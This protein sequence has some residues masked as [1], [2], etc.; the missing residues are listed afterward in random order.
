MHI[1]N[2]KNKQI[3]EL[4]L[5]DNEYLIKVPVKESFL[6][7]YHKF[8]FTLEERE[9]GHILPISATETEKQNEFR[10]FK[11]FLPF[12]DYENTFLENDIWNVYLV[13]ED[14]DGYQKRSRIA[15]NYDDIRF[16]TI[17]VPE[18]ELMFYP[19]RTKKGKL[20]FRMNDYFTYGMFDE[21]ALTE[22]DL[23]FSGYFNFPPYYKT[24]DYEIKDISLIVTDNTSE[25]EY[26]I[27]LERFE[28]HD[29]QDK[30]EGN[31]NLV[32][33]GIKG[34]FDIPATLS[35]DQKHYFKFHLEI[36][37]LKDSEMFSMRSSRVRVDH[38]SIQLPEKKVIN[39][40]N[41]KAKLLVKSTKYS[42]Y[43]SFQMSYYNFKRELKKS[44]KNKWV[45]TRRS[46]KLLQAYKLAFFLL[47]KLPVKK[48][49]IMFESFLGKQFSDSPR[50]IYEYLIENYPEYQMYWSADRR[51]TK[52]FE[53]KNVNYVRRFSIRWLILMSRAEFWVSNSRLP[54]WIPK[55][56]HTT[57]L[58]T[59]HGTPLKRLAVDMDEVHMPGTNS[60]KYKR[61][62]V[63]AT[64]RW[65]YLVSP[66]AY[67]TEI[68]KRAFQ[69]QGEM[70]E[71]GYPR[72]DFLINDNNEQTIRSIKERI[73]LPTDKKVIL[74]A[75]TWRDNQFYGK[76]KYRFQ[77][78]M[79]L[80]KMQKHLGDDYI[81]LL[82]M[83]YLVAEQLDVDDFQGFVFDV[84]FHED[85]RELYLISDM[86][87]TDYSSVF[88]D[89]ANLKRPM[90]F[91]VYDIEEYR[92]N[93]RGF[94]FDFEAKAPG[95]LVQTTD[96][97]LDVI[98]EIDQNGFKPSETTQ[99]FYKRFCYLED[100]QASE[101]V[102]KD[103][104]VD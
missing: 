37:Y 41:Q 82:R 78:E 20:S 73:D 19:F 4:A 21:V 30:Y 84:S 80:A 98:Q 52:F 75:P 87:I 49:T 24:D 81:I 5:K 11:L 93:L 86:L 6:E 58:Q 42:K 12:N 59:W 43:L 68:F 27:P 96:E 62:F 101:R 69:F 16:S 34:E 35:L 102:A 53:D 8:H 38:T 13:R 51:H 99:N 90:L 97:I 47:G 83:H 85:I 103:V 55:P 54:L 67:S 17:V 45:K 61:N 2:I 14:E 56:K 63:K 10:V 92:D 3:M 57:Y 95:P 89:Y 71:S 91:F 76:G 100:G 18:K 66:N 9:T 44:V 7:K 26:I 23:I 29:L 28:R 64:S 40:H 1:N 39:Y 22:N 15:S 33:C 36:T 88:F 72:N 46:D 104:F 32:H 94:Y 74:Y 48:N 79:D 50:A 25:E 31:D 70:V 77:L 60:V 65:D